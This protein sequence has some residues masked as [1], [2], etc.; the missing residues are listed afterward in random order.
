MPQQ[1]HSLP[2]K[3]DF[4]AIDSDELSLVALRKSVNN[5]DFFAKTILIYALNNVR[6]FINV[7][8]NLTNP[9]IEILSE[10]IV[11]KYGHYKMSEIKSVLYNGMM[12]EKIYGRL[13]GNMIMQWFEAYDCERVQK[14]MELS[15]LEL[16]QQENASRPSEDGISFDEYKAQLRERASKGDKEASAKLANLEAPIKTRMTLTSDER[17]QKEI[18]FQQWK[19]NEYQRKSRR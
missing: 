16:D 12:K 3:T 15:D 4:S 9:Q 19:L 2:V 5:G 14:A 8:R 13:D 18:A 6:D 7:E 17:R 1:W 11:A 10:M